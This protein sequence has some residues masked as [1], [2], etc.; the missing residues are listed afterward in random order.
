[1]I[2]SLLESQPALKSQASWRGGNH[3]AQLAAQVEVEIIPG[4]GGDYS[5]SRGR[6]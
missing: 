3:M 2:D 6:T 5:N 1:M 4:G